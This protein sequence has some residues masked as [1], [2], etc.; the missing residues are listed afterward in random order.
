M[1]Y[2]YLN[3]YELCYQ[4]HENDDE[5]A[6]KLIFSKYQPCIYKIVHNYYQKYKYI[7]IDEEDLIQE[8]KIGL[9]KA[10]KSYTDEDSLF[11]TYAN[12]CMERQLISY[13]RSY[14]NMKNYP[15][16][17]NVGEEFC[18]RISEDTVSF[19]KVED[20]LMENESYFEAM[21][22][23]DFK[24]RIVYELRHNH[25]TYREIAELLDL[26]TSTVDGRLRY[27]R[28]VLNDNLN[29]SI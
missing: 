28:K 12:I 2:K 1:D 14:N 15:L 8:A 4:V 25:F 26:P 13:C 6:L 7:G 5:D 9:M 19:S 22:L 3:D 21:D 24:Y 20:I 23:L 11:Y 29:M 10:L 17:H 27:I 16:N 18:Y